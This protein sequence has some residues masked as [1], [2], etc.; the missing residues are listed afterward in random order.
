MPLDKRKA[1]RLHARYCGAVSRE[2]VEMVRRSVEAY[3]RGDLEGVSA[4]FASDFE[5]VASGSP[6]RSGGL[7]GA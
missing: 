3:N 6:R 4:E 5:Y 2:N 7:P 1:N